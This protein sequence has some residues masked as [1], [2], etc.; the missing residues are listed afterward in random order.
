MRV[1]DARQSRESSRYPSLEKLR[2]EA[3]ESA[4]VGFP[5]ASND[6]DRLALRVSQLSR[7]AAERLDEINRLKTAYN[8]ERSRDTGDTAGE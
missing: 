3:I 2:T 5:N 6:I 7:L 4:T 8:A 1:G